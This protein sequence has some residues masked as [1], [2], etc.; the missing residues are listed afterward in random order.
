MHILSS[1]LPP[2][3]FGSTGI[4]T[5]AW[6]TVENEADTYSSDDPF[7][8]DNNVTTMYFFFIVYVFS[9]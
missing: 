1:P 9:D 6:N 5:R 7:S 2:C 4:N 8:N 3:P